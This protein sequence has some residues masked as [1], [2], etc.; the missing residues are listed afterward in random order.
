MRAGFLL[1]FFK[2]GLAIGLNFVRKDYQRIKLEELQASN[3]NNKKTP[4]RLFSEPSQTSEME[5]FVKIVNDIQSLTIFRRK[6]CV[7]C[8]TGFWMRHWF[9][10]KFS[11]QL[12]FK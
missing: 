3:F 10:F 7:R 8:L 1:L 12:L 2:N 6:L 4:L 11:Q 5:L 9:S